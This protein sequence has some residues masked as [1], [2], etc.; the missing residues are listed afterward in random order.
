MSSVTSAH[1]FEKPPL[2]FEREHPKVQYFPAIE[3]P[4]ISGSIL[5]PVRKNY[6]RSL[7][8]HPLSLRLHKDYVNGNLYDGP[9]VVG[10]RGTACR[11]DSTDIDRTHITKSLAKTLEDQSEMVGGFGNVIESD[12]STPHRYMEEFVYDSLDGFVSDFLLYRPSKLREKVS[13]KTEEKFIFPLLL[14]YDL[15]QVERYGLYGIR[16]INGQP[17]SR[18]CLIKAIVLDYPIK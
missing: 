14:I 6:F 4:Q 9:P 16:Q 15:R 3:N 2:P 7:V 11:V 13:G 8:T 18:N 5:H 1:I 17:P 12:L 10:F